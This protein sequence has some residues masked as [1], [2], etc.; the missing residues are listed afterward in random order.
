MDSKPRSVDWRSILLVIFA[1]GGAF[2]AIVTAIG[3]LIFIILNES[4]LMRLNAPRL[5]SVL[6]AST[7]LAIGLLLLPV[8]WL[9][10]K[11]L[12]GSD[13]DSFVLSP[14]RPWTWISLPGIWL[15]VII[16]GTL[17]SDAPGAVWFVPF[18]HFLAIA[19]P[20]TFVIHIAINTIP[21]GSSQ[22]AW[23]VFGLGMTLGPLLAVI[24]EVTMVIL[25]I[26]LLA[27][28][29]GLNSNTIAEI[30]RFV[31]QIEQA[32]NLDSLIYQVEPL[33]RNPLT[34]FAGLA[35]LSFLVPIIEE[36]AK[37][38]GVWLVA[39][40]F[41]SPAQG[42][43]LGALSGAGFALAESLSASLSVDATWG[44]TL[45]MRAISGS[46][47]ILA[48]GLFGWGIAYARLEKRYF[49]A[50]GMILLAMLLHSAWNAGAVFS[51]WG[52]ARV[53][54]AMPGV[55]VPG[56]IVAAVGGGL[57]LFMMVGMFLAFFILNRRFRRFSIPPLPRAEV[58]ESIVSPG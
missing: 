25:G 8:G 35:F 45:S 50:A 11:R 34:L 37:S 52:G 40:R 44:V 5:T 46:M 49:R 14:L 22:R 23:G 39:D 43:A 13:F 12:S 58:Q 21:L 2:V 31:N 4:A 51:L 9:S 1:L 57:L 15:I 41:Q 48:S 53:M 33:L 42:F 24:A 3:I 26:L 27:V 38:L 30:E 10:V 56:T 28:Y 16:L 54:F 29:L 32:P 7:I 55:D 17:Y 19:L 47:H 36:T 20:I 6:T 18:L